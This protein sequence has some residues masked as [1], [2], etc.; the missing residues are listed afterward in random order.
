MHIAID[1]QQ[2]NKAIRIELQNNLIHSMKL[3]VGL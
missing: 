1:E 2:M 3:L